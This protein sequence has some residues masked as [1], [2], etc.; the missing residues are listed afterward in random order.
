MPTN[1]P[2]ETEAIQGLQRSTEVIN[3]NLARAETPARVIQ[4]ALD[5]RYVT[6]I[7]KD[8]EEAITIAL[9]TMAAM[10]TQEGPAVF[11]AIALQM[12]HVVNE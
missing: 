7:T 8:D 1:L 11:A 2:D 12:F 9:L 5:A 3:R 4:A 10:Y 6:G